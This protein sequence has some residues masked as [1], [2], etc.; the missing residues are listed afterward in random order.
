L[1]GWTLD[2]VFEKPRPEQ[3]QVDNEYFY[4]LQIGKLKPISFFDWED[5]G[6]WYDVEKYSDLYSRTQYMVNWLEPSTTYLARVRARHASPSSAFSCWGDFAYL[7]TN[8]FEPRMPTVNQIMDEWDEGIGTFCIVVRWTHPDLYSL[9]SV[10]VYYKEA[11]VEVYKVHELS[12]SANIPSMNHSLLPKNES[13]CVNDFGPDIVW[14]EIINAGVPARQIGNSTFGFMTAG[15]CSQNT[16]SDLGK[17]IVYSCTAVTADGATAACATDCAFGA[18]TSDSQLVRVCNLKPDTEYSIRTVVSDSLGSSSDC[19]MGGLTNLVHKTPALPPSN[20]T[21]DVA[22]WSTTIDVRVRG[23]TVDILYYCA[24]FEVLH[25]VTSIDT[26]I[27]DMRIALDACSQKTTVTSLFPSFTISGLQPN[28]TYILITGISSHSG[29]GSSYPQ[30]HKTKSKVP[31]CVAFEAFGDKSDSNVYS[32]H[33]FMII[34]FDKQTNQPNFQTNRV[35]CNIETTLWAFN[36]LLP[37]ELIPE[38]IDEG[39][40]LKLTIAKTNNITKESQPAIGLQK[41]SID[42]SCFGLTDSDGTSDKV[43][44]SCPTLVGTWGIARPSKTLVVEATKVQLFREDSV[45]LLS[46]T[47]CLTHI[48]NM[49][50]DKS[51]CNLVITQQPSGASEIM[52]LSNFGGKC[53]QIHQPL[54]PGSELP[55]N[56][57]TSFLVDLSIKCGKPS[58]EI[59]NVRTVVSIDA[60]DD[61]PLLGVSPEIHILANGN[62]L[63]LFSVWDSLVTEVD[64]EVVVVVV[65]IA[66]SGATLRTSDRNEG[67]QFM[68]KGTADEVNIELMGL[69]LAVNTMVPFDLFA[70]VVDF[71][72]DGLEN[73]R[74]VV[75]ASSTINPQCAPNLA[76]GLASVTINPDLFGVTVVFT[77][78]VYH[79]LS[80]DVMCENLIHDETVAALGNGATCVVESYVVDITSGDELLRG[81]LVLAVTFGVDATLAPLDSFKTLAVGKLLMCN[82]QI[83]GSIEAV[84]KLP[85]S[86][87]MVSV[88]VVLE[89]NTH[90][91]GLCD[92]LVVTAAVQGTGPWPVKYAW[93][94]PSG[95]L[96]FGTTLSVNTHEIR[97]PR[98]QWP[99]KSTNYTIY[100]TATAEHTQHSDSR[101]IEI[102]TTL[103]AKPK[104]AV[105]ALPSRLVTSCLDHAVS[106]SL[107]HGLCGD[108]DAVLVYTWSVFGN[109]GSGDIHIPGPWTSN[110]DS[111][112]LVVTLT[113][114]KSFSLL[115][116][117]RIHLH[118]ASKGSTLANEYDIPLNVVC[119]PSMMITGGSV[120]LHSK[121]R[122]F[123]LESLHEDVFNHDE[124]NYAWTCQ[125]INSA[126]CF[127][128]FISSTVLSFGA[129][130][131]IPACGIA[132]GEY[133]LSVCGGTGARRVCAGVKLQIVDTPTLPIEIGLKVGGTYAIRA[134]PSDALALKATVSQSSLNRDLNTQSTFEWSLPNYPGDPPTVDSVYYQNDKSILAF[135][136]GTTVDFKVS[137]HLKD[138]LFAGVQGAGT[139]TIRIPANPSGGVVS[140]K[141]VGPKYILETAGWGGTADDTKLKYECFLAFGTNAVPPEAKR[142]YLHPRMSTV[143]RYELAYRPVGTLTVGCLAHNTPYGSGL[144]T[145]CDA[146]G[147]DCSAI[148]TNRSVK[149]RR[150][151]T[152]WSVPLP[153]SQI[154]RHFSENANVLDVSRRESDTAHDMSSESKSLLV[155]LKAAEPATKSEAERTGNIGPLSQLYMIATSSMTVESYSEHL[156]LGALTFTARYILSQGHVF[157]A[158]SLWKIMLATNTSL[159][160]LKRVSA[161]VLVDTVRIVFDEVLGGNHAPPI[162]LDTAATLVAC[163]QVFGD[164]SRILDTFLDKDHSSL[165]GRRKLEVSTNQ[166]LS[167]R[168]HFTQMVIE[169]FLQIAQT[170]ARGPDS[171]VN[172]GTVIDLSRR[173]VQ[174]EME[175]T[176]A[177]VTISLASGINLGKYGVLLRGSGDHKE[178]HVIS[179]FLMSLHCSMGE[180]TKTPLM[181]GLHFSRVAAQVA[182]EFYDVVDF[183]NLAAEYSID[184]PVSGALLGRNL[185]CYSWSHNN[186]TWT[187]DGVVTGKI[188]VAGWEHIRCSVNDTTIPPPFL[189][190]VF[191][192]KI[193]VNN[194]Q[195]ATELKGTNEVGIVVTFRNTT[196]VHDMNKLLPRLFGSYFALNVEALFLEVVAGK[197]GVIPGSQKLVDAS[198]TFEWIE[199]QDVATQLA[200][201]SHFEHSGAKILLLWVKVALKYINL[202][203]AEIHVSFINTALSH[204]FA[205][206]VTAGNSARID[207]GVNDVFGLIVEADLKLVYVRQIVPPTLLLTS[208]FTTAAPATTN[209]SNGTGN[210]NGTGDKPVTNVQK[211]SEGPTKSTIIGCSI[212]AAI[213]CAAGLV[214]FVKWKFRHRAPKIEPG[215]LPV[216]DYSKNLNVE[217]SRGG[218]PKIQRPSWVPTEETATKTRRTSITRWHPQVNGVQEDSSSDNSKKNTQL[219]DQLLPSASKEPSTFNG[220]WKRPIRPSTNLRPFDAA[221][222]TLTNNLSRRRLSTLSGIRASEE[223]AASLN[224]VAGDESSS[225]SKDGEISNLSHPYSQSVL[226]EGTVQKRS[227]FEDPGWGSNEMSNESLAIELENELNEQRL[228]NQRAISH[229]VSRM[230]L[231]T[232]LQRRKSNAG[233]DPD[234]D[235]R[236]DTQTDMVSEKSNTSVIEDD[237]DPDLASHQASRTSVAWG[238]LLGITS[239][240]ETSVVKR[241]PILTP[242]AKRQNGQHKPSVV[243][244][245]P[246]PKQA[247]FVFRIP[248]SGALTTQHQHSRHFGPTLGK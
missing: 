1:R 19:C 57:V 149:R 13:F 104:M 6:D 32:V 176:V 235:I 155:E 96:L 217:K 224:A 160:S 178:V 202:N 88:A 128:C 238:A 179:V 15:I 147:S 132:S 4:E 118:V 223:Q 177:K 47:V 151:S 193:A 222:E 228:T 156:I 171:P 53:K 199:G 84:V 95:Q 7:E 159:L 52:S 212:T 230:S 30:Q 20:V 161:T 21:M 33:D 232:K 206:F 85:P 246:G 81:F 148:N 157:S 108:P 207:S 181:K 34:K 122:A 67:A 107:P 27:S 51:S 38:W 54:P 198:A 182:V 247:P 211:N 205:A 234:K 39:T 92:D 18:C 218:P 125:G 129:N 173:Q 150:A 2:V 124:V 189:I 130:L 127:D 126:P 61:L 186:W 26:E 184:F 192:Q 195:L 204:S 210:T 183:F 136:A 73:A 215:T 185:V 116:E 134:A 65:H 68:F 49:S 64:G 93:T 115:Q 225:S 121:T 169:R 43:L 221:N 209:N 113:A 77:E 36:P 63:S 231:T 170:F 46:I 120:Q 82:K 103:N 190:S 213:L 229:K 119:S 58:E 165:R 22:T 200:S 143:K 25:D 243:R 145:I 99:Q 60:V 28:T 140:F 102:A 131:D 48:K 78:V 56:S 139:I 203:D 40:T 24:Y 227:T 106:L 23:V 5:D 12:V 17:S 91:L 110:S 191:E 144:F 123:Q 62:F 75:F 208:A 97:I 41:V 241:G 175:L 137:S 153:L 239:S 69:E 214:M 45:V 94:E 8:A 3:F 16:T 98:G 152:V 194:T 248:P 237:T 37:A 135:K 240:N 86:D 154:Q 101:F 9:R 35:E 163:A 100:L 10:L 158:D 236:L 74:T 166:Y 72:D 50:V 76:V 219:S 105:D 187:T 79:K 244:K 90:T 29:S 242:R 11:E 174:S 133:D 109:L 168:Q 142:M 162:Q 83:F 172:S 226:A 167:N 180:Y 216:K 196:Q 146:V 188:G 111:A 66:S 114:L 31:K 14:A 197:I 141:R 59:E 233:L 71:N 138:P 80:A 112:T 220:S 201:F 70:S 55:P 164:I 42:G 44:D 117:Y 245:I 89:A 87:T